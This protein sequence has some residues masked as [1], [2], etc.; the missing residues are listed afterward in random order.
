MPYLRMIACDV[1]E[2][3]IQD[4]IAA[5]D[6]AVEKAKEEIACLTICH[7]YMSTVIC[8]AHKVVYIRNRR[9]CAICI[10]FPCDEYHMQDVIAAIDAAVEK[11]K[12]EVESAQDASCAVY[13]RSRRQYTI[14]SM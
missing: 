10:R 6:A 11:A 8:T 9:Q 1:Y 12:E 13:I 4:V 3:H 5:I 2:Y 7:I 14:Y